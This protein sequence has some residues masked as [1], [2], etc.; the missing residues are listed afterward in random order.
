MCLCPLNLSL[1]LLCRFRSHSLHNL[2]THSTSYS[3]FTSVFVYSQYH[4]C[5]CHSTHSIMSVFVRLTLSRVYLSQ[6][7]SIM[8]VFVTDSQWFTSDYSTWP[9]LLLVMTSLLT[10]E[11]FPCNCFIIELA[12]ETNHP[13]LTVLFQ[14][15]LLL[16]N[17][18]HNF[19]LMFAVDTFPCT[20]NTVEL[21]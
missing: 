10:V 2:F 9:P 21:A 3:V 7:H 13:W 4:E 20:C 18:Q 19:S 12:K 11:T 8:S 6:T 17:T 14:G 1:T 16:E 15:S 5:I